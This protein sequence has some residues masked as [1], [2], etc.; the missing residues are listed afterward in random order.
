MGDIRNANP[1]HLEQLAD[2]L[3]TAGDGGAYGRLVELFTRARELDASGELASL[4][5]LLSW[6]TDAADQ[7][8]DGASILRGDG[9]S[10]YGVA[11][12][13]LMAGYHR[14]TGEDGEWEWEIL[15]QDNADAIVKIA[16]RDDELTEEEI[17][18]I[19]GLLADFADQP[20][21]AAH[22]VD[23][24]GMEEF[25]RLW[26]RVDGAVGD[27]DEDAEGDA[28]ALRSSM[29][30]VLAAAMWV[31]GDLEPGT[32]AYQ[33]WLV[34]D[35]GRRYAER[36]EAFNLAGEQPFEVA[37]GEADSEEPE[38]SVLGFDIALDL[39]ERAEHP[40]DTAFLMQTMTYLT[41]PHLGE[42]NICPAWTMDVPERFV[43]VAAGDNPQETL[44]WWNDLGKGRQDALIEMAPAAVGYMDGIPAEARDRANRLYLPTLI[45]ELEGRDDADSQRKL[46]GLLRIQERLG[47]ETV[48]PMFLLGIGDEGNGRAI[49]SFGNPD[50][51]ENVSAYVPGLDTRLDAS[52][53]NGT[54][55]RALDTAQTAQDVDPTSTTASI[56]WLGY[57]APIIGEG[58]SLM[59]VDGGGWGLPEKLDVM[60]DEHAREGA[61][62]YQQFIEGLNVT[63]HHE[64]LHLTA[65]GHSYGSLTMA[66]A[67]QEPGG[68]NADDV[69][70]IGSPG[71]GVD[72]AED[73]GVGAD[74]VYVG[75]ADNDVVTRLPS[76]EEAGL[77]SFGAVLGGLSLGPLGAI[78][79]ADVGGKI[80]DWND[81][82]IWFGRDPA[83]ESFGGQRFG[84]DD[85]LPLFEGGFDAHSNYF[86]PDIDPESAENIAHIV[87]GNGERISREEPR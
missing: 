41:A 24:M 49:I 6:L 51:A 80:A 57:D 87:T 59:P 70:I 79:G 86:D 69:I 54:V 16:R 48:P 62:A 39:L 85:G 20:D 22:L 73:L 40:V 31:P 38:G 2:K 64:D 66:T 42:A 35:Q 14:N 15:G 56:V 61:P 17:D 44:E 72:H 81:N 5:P 82:E 36:L 28:R 7:L 13:D 75:A 65:I 53:A 11:P 71:V 47:E 46:E 37:D 4:Q 63:S 77:G 19:R 23:E 3:H 30:D 29:G 68:I 76:P 43:R 60:S 52:F 50:E 27:M 55:D 21:F 26:H 67:T 18:E 1:D 8:R 33:E 45:E 32:E 83:S 74:H 34:T 25:L 9:P 12:S 84:V 10:I 78:V 58:A